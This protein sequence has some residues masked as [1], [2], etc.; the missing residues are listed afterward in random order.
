MHSAVSI[1]QREEQ[2]GGSR[3]NTLAQ[4]LTKLT[5]AE[6]FLEF[7]GVPYEESVLNV[8]RLHILKRF[9]QYM[10][11]EHVMDMTNETEMFKLMRNLLA[12][13]YD[14][15]IHSTPAKEKVFSVLQNADGQ[16]V[17]VSSLR[18]SLRKNRSD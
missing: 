18:E 8:S 6:D 17:S 5:S 10:R 9:F 12:K 11:Q 16:R 15:F 13:S 4:R 3:M 1:K 7:F 2:L 14:D